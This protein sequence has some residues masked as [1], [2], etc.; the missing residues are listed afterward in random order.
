MD[1]NTVIELLIIAVIFIF[2]KYQEKVNYAYNTVLVKIAAVAF[3]LLCTV[4]NKWIGLSLGILLVL[5]YRYYAGRIYEGLKK[6]KI[7]VKL[8]K[9]VEKAFT[10]PIKAAEKV[11]VAPIKASVKPKPPPPP[12]P[13]PPEPV[14][15]PV[16]EPAP[17][18]APDAGDSGDNADNKTSEDT[19]AE[20]EDADE[21]TP[22]EDKDVDEDNIEEDEEGMTTKRHSQFKKTYCRQGK[23]KYKN[24]DVKKDMIEHIFPEIKFLYRPCNPCDNTCSFSIIEERLTNEQTLLRPKNSN[25]WYWTVTNNIF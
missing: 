22:V 8:L 21:D 12:P 20:D 15:E 7:N 2:I 23:L 3:V 14:P 25:E 13:P 6:A 18:T 17:Q 16:P 19:P 5:Y 4:Y 1:K 11:V 10:A 24:M 9:S